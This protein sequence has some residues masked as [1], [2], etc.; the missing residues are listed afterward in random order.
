MTLDDDVITMVDL[1]GGKGGKMLE[2]EKSKLHLVVL[3]ALIF[4]GKV[5]EV[6][7][8]KLFMDKYS[9]FFYLHGLFQNFHATCYLS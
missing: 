1:P 4:F 9:F 8:L 2:W 5:F 7:S 3:F 6:V